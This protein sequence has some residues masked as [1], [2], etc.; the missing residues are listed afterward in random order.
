[1]GVTGYLAEQPQSDCNT[2]SHKH[3]SRGF[4]GGL[5]VKN[6][7]AN[8]G[9]LR[10]VGSIS[11]FG[12]S[13]REG[14]GNPLQYS[15]QENSKDRGAWW[16]TV[17]GVTKSW[18]WLK[19]L[20]TS[21]HWSGCLQDFQGLFCVLE[22][23]MGDLWVRVSKGLTWKHRHHTCVMVSQ[24]VGHDLATE[25]TCTHTHPWAFDFRAPVWGKWANNCYCYK[26]LYGYW[27]RL[28]AFIVIQSCLSLEVVTHFKDEKH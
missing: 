9:D 10:D 3:W 28:V 17:H 8:A 23:E 6:Q 22:V 18:P 19:R 13:P 14:N 7:P 15:C 11:G 5:V 26:G 20:G 1:M 21:K 25:H 27:T 4:P 2:G 24:W 12:G 16:V